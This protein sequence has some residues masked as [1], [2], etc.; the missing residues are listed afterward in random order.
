M[1][2]KN[3][4][5]ISNQAD[6]KSECHITL[7]LL[8]GKSNI[9]NKSNPINIVKNGIKITAINHFEKKTGI[10]RTDILKIIWVSERTIMHRSEKLDHK[11]N[12]N[13]SDR[14][15]SFC[16]VFKHAVDFFGSMRKAQAWFYSEL[17]ALN[18]ATPISICDTIQG[19]QLV[20]TILY[21]AEHGIFS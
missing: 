21:R 7:E 1:P 18:Y 16:E 20:N 5:H 10:K 4:T 6:S 14:L 12:C 3:T 9:L 2:D 17:M 11:L 8:L 15:Y 13:E 19:I